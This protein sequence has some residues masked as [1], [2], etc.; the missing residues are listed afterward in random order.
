MISQ[1]GA[2][3][4]GLLDYAQEKQIGFSKIITLGNKA[5][6]DEV[7]FLHHLKDD[8][9]TKVILLYLEDIRRGREF[10][11]VAR[12]V[13]RAGKPIL[14]IKSGRTKGRKSGCL[15]AYRFINRI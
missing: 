2:L 13:T 5:D 15:F 1:S 10:L 11:S 12:E 4:A 7:D 3:A 6:L 8:P 9:L 14:A